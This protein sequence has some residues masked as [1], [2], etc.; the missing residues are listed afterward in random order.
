MRRSRTGTFLLA[1]LLAI[2]SAPASAQEKPQRI[3]SLNL[4]TDQLLLDLAGRERIASVSFLAADPEFSAV[5]EKARGVPAN[6]GLAEEIVALKPDLVLAHKYAGRQAVAMLLRLGV[7]VVEIDLPQDLAAVMA[8]IAVVAE[9]V[10]EQERGR[11]MIAAIEQRLA[12]LPPAA[13]PRL[14]AAIYEPSGFAFGANS[15]A[16]A[17]L[18]AAGYDNLAARLGVG[19]YARLGMEN[20]L[21]NPP[22]ILVVDDTAADR[23]SM[24]QE[25]LDHPA[26][27]QRF[28]GERR[29]AVPRRLW[30]CGGPSVAEAAALLAQARVQRR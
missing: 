18:R 14:T 12:A 30:I 25:F 17:I 13:E 2:L 3:V 6:R 26:L 4:C 1:A 7:R 19:G 24:A 5:A 23:R 27:R 15:L 16:D 11:A 8:Q 9:A 22:D 20:L 10:Q 29:V 21:A 28:A